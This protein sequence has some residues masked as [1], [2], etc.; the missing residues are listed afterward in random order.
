MKTL[1]IVVHC[2]PREID[3][4]ERVLDKLH[5]S[6][7]YLSPKARVVIDVTLNLN[8]AYTDWS[9]SILDKKFFTTK[10]NFLEKKAS[11]AYKT[12]FYVDDIGKCLGINDKRRNS[13][14]SVDSEV[15]YIMY[16]DLDVFFSKVNLAIAFQAFD[17]IP[18]E[19]QIISSQLTKLWDQSWDVISSSMFK[20]SSYNQWKEIDPY[21]IEF[22]VDSNTSNFSI[23]PINT[24][25]FGGGWFN[26]FSTNLLEFIDIPDSLG[27]YGL[28][29]TFIM[30]G[31]KLM[32]AKGYDLV[33]YVLQGAI[34]CEN[35][36]YELY[37]YNPYLK[38]ISDKSI[39]S[40]SKVFKQKWRENASKN[41][42]IELQNFLERI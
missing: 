1:Q 5:E 38:Y 27:P 37:N 40:Q 35:I 2:L 4:L 11:W 36:K 32:Q 8:D 23:S 34:V 9:T 15:N 16:L 39:E 26:I 14:R 25:K 6:S 22:I 31:S 30:E 41:F 21:S 17:Q 10:F 19:Y 12:L 33:Q 42:S 24:V 3:Q 18:N 29:D 7:F 28:D 13:I 20:D